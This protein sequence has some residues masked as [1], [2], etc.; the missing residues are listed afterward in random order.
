LYS[1]TAAG[2]RASDIA[3]FMEAAKVDASTAG[4]WLTAMSVTATRFVSVVS[5]A[6]AA[7]TAATVYVNTSVPRRSSLGAVA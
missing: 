6:P 1:P 4:G 7:S 2:A 3:T 5:E